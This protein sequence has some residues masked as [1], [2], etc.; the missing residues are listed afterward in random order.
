MSTQGVFNLIFMTVMLLLVFADAVFLISSLFNEN[1]S[2]GIGA[3][4]GAMMIVLIYG[5]KVLGNLEV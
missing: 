4:C 1:W 5:L 2:I 3:L